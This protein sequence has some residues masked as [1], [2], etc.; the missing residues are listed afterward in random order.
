M[1]L[2]EGEELL[3]SSES[4]ASAQPSVKL[5]KQTS[6]SLQQVI[7]NNLH[8]LLT[9]RKTYVY[10]EKKNV[11][12]NLKNVSK[13]QFLCTNLILLKSSNISLLDKKCLRLFYINSFI[14]HDPINPRQNHIS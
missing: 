8:T 9:H 14:D 5:R 1:L 11:K 4:H 10:I 6:Q 2:N 7:N 3:L 13:I 12:Q